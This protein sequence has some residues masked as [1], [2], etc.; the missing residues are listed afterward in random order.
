MWNLFQVNNKDIRT[1]DV[2]IAFVVA[3][4]LL[5]WTD[6]AL[7]LGISIVNFEQVNVAYDDPKQHFFWK[8]SCW[9]TTKKKT[10]VSFTVKQNW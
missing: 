10:M 8:E 4:L 9:S 6:F 2:A 1:T 7:C 5:T 3:S